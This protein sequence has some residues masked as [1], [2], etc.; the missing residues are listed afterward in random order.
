MDK[1]FSIKIESIKTK[2]SI[3][4]TATITYIGDD[5]KLHSFLDKKRKE[6]IAYIKLTI[7]PIKKYNFIIISSKLNYNQPH[8]GMLNLFYNYASMYNMYSEFPITKK[9]KGASYA[10]LMCCFCDALKT[11]YITP[12]SKIFLEASGTIEGTDKVESMKKLVKHYESLGFEQAFPDLYD[13]AIEYE[14]VPMIGSVKDIVNNCGF[15]N[16][17][18]ELKDILP[19]QMC[20]DIC[21]L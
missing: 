6:H 1:D 12:S 16:I 10:L 5:D 17:S 14:L 7:T 13:K 21:N 9:L 3:R 2:K 19:I 20:L 15:D 11:G 8:D 4:Y 18:K